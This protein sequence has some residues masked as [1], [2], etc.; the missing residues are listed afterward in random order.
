M[1]PNQGA[2]F[3]KNPQGGGA[4]VVLVE[5]GHDNRFNPARVV[6]MLLDQFATFGL[7]GDSTVDQDSGPSCPEHQTISTASGTD[8]FEVKR[9][10]FGR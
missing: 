7:R 6:H 8:R 5:V 3:P 1:T 9:H 4:D 10:Y 2:V